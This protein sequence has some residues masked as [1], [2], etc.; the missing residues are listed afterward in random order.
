[1]VNGETP[2]QVED[3]AAAAATLGTDRP[4]GFS[5]TRVI[6]VVLKASTNECD[7]SPCQ[8]LRKIGAQMADAFLAIPLTEDA[9]A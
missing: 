1:M 2:D 6:G 4:S 3:L 5:P 7:C 9:K 8:E